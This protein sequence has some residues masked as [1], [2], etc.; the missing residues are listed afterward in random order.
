MTRSLEKNVDWARLSALVA[1]R[2]GLSYPETRWHDLERGLGRAALELGLEHAGVLAERVLSEPTA[3]K[4]L[5]LLANHLT[6]GETYFFRD[7]RTFQYLAEKVLPAIIRERRGGEQ[8]LRL[9]SAG[10]CTGEEA[11]SLAILVTQL[12]PDLKKWQVTVLATDVNA[13]FLK[14]AVNGVYGEW[15]FR[16]V[17]TAVK[18]KYFTSAGKGRYQI[19]PEVQDLVSFAHLNLVEDIYPSIATD[20]NAMDVVLCRNVLMYFT[21]L[22]ISK[23][24]ERVRLCLVVG[25]TLC[26]SPTEASAVN[27]PGWVQRSHG[28]LSFYEKPS[29]E[30]Q[31]EASPESATK[32]MWQGHSYEAKPP[33]SL[34][35]INPPALTSFKGRA[36]PSHEAPVPLS[37]EA[38]LAHFQAGRYVSATDM[39]LALAE[40]AKKQAEIFGLLARS[41]GNQGRLTEALEWCDLW[42]ASDKMNRASHYL[43]A[44]VLM[45]SGDHVQARVSFRKA[46]YLDPDFVLAHFAMG[47]LA[48]GAHRH[49]DAARHFSQATRL[50]RELPHD[51]LLPESDGLTAGRLMETIASL[52]PDDSLHS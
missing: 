44:M 12:L 9:W 7:G 42:I 8:R 21:P 14:H 30:E 26:V 15:S 49:R 16:E 17:A 38:A 34:R 11:Y 45:E 32:D 47:H 29:E 13:K 28:G 39:L 50:L 3:K 31:C 52:V 27:F 43:R 36:S 6:I 48:L 10:C 22:Q 24:I 25:G 23:V 2:L 20:T 4:E 1:D 5:Q 19:L 46:L 33:E 35:P 18:Q 51:Q 37:F 41:L 40:P